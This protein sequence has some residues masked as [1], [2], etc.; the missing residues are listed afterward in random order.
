MKYAMFVFSFIH[1]TVS[2]G[3]VPDA[4]T[5][6]TS[7]NVGIGTATP[8]EKL[9]V[10]GRIKDEVGYVMPKGCIVMW[11]GAANNIPEGWALCDGFNGTPD[12]R[13]RFIVGAGVEYDVDEK[14][15]TD[16]IALTIDQMPA[17]THSNKISS[18]GYHTH[19]LSRNGGPP[20]GYDWGGDGGTKSLSA[21]ADRAGLAGIA[22]D[23]Q[24]IHS[25]TATINSTGGGQS[26]ENRPSFWALCYII[27]L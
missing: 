25:H 10:N 1:F 7:G 9:E 16:S 18:N 20:L 17:H 8:S 19:N 5:I 3:Q 6:D 21:G 12:L 23:M 27:K 11:S 26:H 2:I 13:G 4:L 22:T 24:G 15:G 14:G